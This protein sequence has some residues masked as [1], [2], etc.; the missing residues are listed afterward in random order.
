MATVRKKRRKRKSLR[1]R[2]SA[3]AKTTPEIHHHNPGDT[4][5]SPLTPSEL[6]AWPIDADGSLSEPFP[7]WLLEGTKPTEEQ[8]RHLTEL[9]M[10]LRVE[11]LRRRYVKPM[12]EFQR[13]AG[14]LRKEGRSLREIERTLGVPV[15]QVSRAVATLKDELA[16]WRTR[17]LA[18][19]DVIYVDLDGF[20]LRVR[21][22]GK[23]V[24]V[25]VLGV[26]GVFP[27][28][29]KHRL[30]LEL[31]G[32]ESFAAWKGC[33]T[34]LAA[35]RALESSTRH[36]RPPGMEGRLPGRTCLSLEGRRSYQRQDNVALRR[37]SWKRE[38]Q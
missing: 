8:E 24:S 21:S 19:L 29:H 3:K 7:P 5:W 1:V 30:A 20:A 23:V 13:R 2:H 4:E 14:E 10:Q 32:G 36:R 12:L 35:T 22:V 31:C 25:P 18:D 11:S 9:V 6:S 38:R 17:S 27:D 16:T 28:G 26:I 33:L 34:T 37:G 15:F